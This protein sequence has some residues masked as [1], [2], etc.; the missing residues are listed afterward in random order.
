LLHRRAFTTVKGNKT[1]VNN[2]VIIEK[3]FGEKGLCCLNDAVNEL[4]SIG[5]NFEELKSIFCTFELS[6]P[7]GKY[8]ERI[9]K[10]NKELEQQTGFKGDAF[11]D[12][13]KSIV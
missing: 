13:L 1:P 12:F 6:K 10:L 8:E 2:N 5:P 9:L 4:Y 3:L 11:D 7:I